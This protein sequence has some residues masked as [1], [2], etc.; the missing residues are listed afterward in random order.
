MAAEQKELG[1]AEFKAGNYEKAISFFTKSI[2]LGGDHVLYSNRSACYAG[3]G[4]WDEALKDAES[5]I[6]KS[7][8]WAK[9]RPSAAP[10]TARRRARLL[11]LTLEESPRAHA[12]RWGHASRSR[13]AYLPLTARLLRLPLEA[14]AN[15]R[16]LEVGRAAS[17]PAPGPCLQGARRSPE[18][19]PARP[20]A[21]AALKPKP[22]PQPKPNPNAQGFGRK[23]AA[24]HGQGR[25][26]KAIAAY[27]EGL[28]I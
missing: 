1:N 27:E 20:H 11:R 19:T 8:T 5:C 28:K 25:F 12:A 22:N 13:A 24:L 26:D 17:R 16:A 9:V 14:P 4:K 10:I 15:P 3:L 2:E 18:L 6:E 23:G 7:P 21:C